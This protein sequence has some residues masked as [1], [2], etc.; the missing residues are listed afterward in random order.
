MHGQ[1]TAATTSR[2]LISRKEGFRKLH[3]GTTKGHDLI[4][5]G[6]IKAFKLDGKTLLCED[7]IDELLASL[8]AVAA[9]PR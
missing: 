5:R 4:K 2:R 6:K 8:P 3:V 7:S 9:R 1:P